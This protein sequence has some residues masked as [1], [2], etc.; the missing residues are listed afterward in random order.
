MMCVEMF[1]DE[2][3]RTEG[4]RNYSAAEISPMSNSSSETPLAQSKSVPSLMSGSPLSGSLCALVTPFD[5]SPAQRF[6]AQLFET[7]AVQ[8][9]EGGSSAL[10]PCGT[11]GESPTIDDDE[12]EEMIRISVAVAHGTDLKVIPGT[13][14]NS[15]REACRHTERAASLGAHGCLIVTPYYNKPSAAGVVRHFEE[16]NKIQVP[17]IIYNIPGRT[18]IQIPAET[19]RTIAERCPYVVAVKAANGD[20]EDISECC[21]ITANLPQPFSILS[22]DDALT[23]PILAVGGTGVVSVIANVLPRTSAEMVRRFAAGDLLGARILSQAMFPLAKALLRTGPNPCPIKA[24]LTIGGYPVGGCRLPLVSLEN[25]PIEQLLSAARQTRAAL[26]A[27]EFSYDE[28][29]DRIG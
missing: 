9:R 23:L 13:G 4:D 27:V 2:L 15:T 24:L 26:R 1:C 19:I 28:L 11:T 16:L 17:L 25:G 5:E 6:N 18:G 3:M 21:A 29:L 7:L 12:F 14:S 20:L 8:Q 10:V 22:G